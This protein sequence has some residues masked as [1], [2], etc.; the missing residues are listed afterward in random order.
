MFLSIL[1]LVGLNSVAL[2]PIPDRRSVNMT[3]IE[4]CTSPIYLREGE[5]AQ[6]LREK[7]RE[8]KKDHRRVRESIQ[9][10]SLK[11]PRTYVGSRARNE[12][13]FNGTTKPKTET[14]DKKIRTVSNRGSSYNI[15]KQRGLASRQKGIFRST[16]K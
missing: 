5:L 10:R 7:K 2:P 14:S 9:G 12:G 8:E 3:V 1:S 15:I 16:T 4:R 13:L 6:C 11:S